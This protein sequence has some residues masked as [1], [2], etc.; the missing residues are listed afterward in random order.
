MQ[1]TFRVLL[2]GWIARKAYINLLAAFSR[3]LF[4]DFVEVDL[5]RSWKTTRLNTAKSSKVKM[6][7]NAQKKMQKQLYMYIVL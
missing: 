3:S 1:Y 5:T 4:K 7:I 6:H 2:L